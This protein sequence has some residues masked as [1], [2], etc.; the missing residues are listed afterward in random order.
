MRVRQ[1]DTTSSLHLAKCLKLGTSDRAGPP[2]GRPPP[3][4]QGFGSCSHG[5]LV[6]GA[7]PLLPRP[8]RSAPRVTTLPPRA[9][10]FSFSRSRVLTAVRALRES[11][12]RSVHVVT[13]STACSKA[14]ASAADGSRRPLTLRTYWRRRRGS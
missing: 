13:S 1:F 14:G 6:G 8:V 7:L 2:D 9:R 10:A 5:R 3:S 11:R 4:K 12:R